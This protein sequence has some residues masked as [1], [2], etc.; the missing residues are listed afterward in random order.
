MIMESVI[1]TT[2]GRRIEV[3]HL[4]LEVQQG[5]LLNEAENKKWGVEALLNEYI[6]QILKKTGN[7]KTQ[8]AKLLG[9]SLNKL[10]RHLQKRGHE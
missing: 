8:A 7:N 5:A 6:K 1:V 4:P 10:K 3:E 9:W 2:E